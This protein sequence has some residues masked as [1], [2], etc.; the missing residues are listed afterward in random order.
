[1]LFLIALEV[2]KQLL[3]AYYHYVGTFQ[4]FYRTTNFSEVACGV[5]SIIYLNLPKRS[6]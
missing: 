2:L 4:K 5:Q 3:F 1:M 6:M